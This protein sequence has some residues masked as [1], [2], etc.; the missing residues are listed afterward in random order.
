M[1]R[2]EFAGW[3]RYKAESLVN[4]DAAERGRL[5]TAHGMA[6]DPDG[7]KRVEDAFGLDYCRKVYPEAYSVA[8]M[9]FGFSRILDRVRE[10]IP[11]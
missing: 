9:R 8:R 2:E 5:I 11:W 7:R 4:P 10:L 1:T 6:N 3:Q